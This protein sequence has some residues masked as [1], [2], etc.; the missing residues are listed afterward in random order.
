M[1][2]FTENQ[3]E[4]YDTFV[5]NRLAQMRNKEE[6]NQKSA[7]SAIRFYGAPILPPVLTDTRIAEMQQ[8]KE[9]AMRNAVSRRMNG[10]ERLAYVQTILHSVQMRHSPTL[11]DLLQE[12]KVTP[13]SLDS[14]DSSE[15]S[16]QSVNTV[17]E[18]NSPHI[19][20]LSSTT[21]SA[22]SS[23][24]VIPQPNHKGGWLVERCR[25]QQASESE[26]SSFNSASHCSVS[27][28]C[29]TRAIMEN[30]SGLSESLDRSNDGHGP[31]GTNNTTDVFLHKTSKR[32]AS[33]QD[34]ISYPP[35]DGE[36]LERSGQESSFCHDF[37]TRNE[38]SIRSDH[39]PGEESASSQMQSTK[40]QHNPPS[41]AVLNMKEGPKMKQVVVPV[42]SLD[43]CST[44]DIAELPQTPSI[45][46]SCTDQLTQSNP[47]NSETMDT[48]VPQ[49]Q[50]QPPN[51]PS[52]QDL[53]R[54]SQEYRWQQRM[55]RNQAKNARMQEKAQEQPRVEEK[56][57]SDKE[58]NEFHSKSTE[59][60]K[61]KEKR[62]VKTINT[63][64]KKYSEKNPVFLDELI[65]KKANRDPERAPEQ[66]TLPHSQP[67][68]QS[69]TQKV[70]HMT[71]EQATTDPVTS[72]EGH[73]THHS[74]P[75]PHF[76]PSPV[77]NKGSSSLP[78]EEDN[79]RGNVSISSSY[80]ESYE[81]DERNP[82]L[83]SDGPSVIVQSS[84]H[85][86]QLESGLSVLKELIS[87]LG[88][89]LM[90]I[91]G[92][93]EERPDEDDVGKRDQRN[94]EG[95]DRQSLESWRSVLE[96]T[97][98]QNNS[99]KDN[100]PSILQDEEKEVV[101]LE[102]FSLVNTFTL[103]GK[104]NEDA[105]NMSSRQLEGNRTQQPPAK[106][107]L[108]VAKW[109]PIPDV[110]R[111]VPSEHTAPHDVSVL[112]SSQS[113][114]TERK[115]ELA[116]DS[117]SFTSRLSV[118]RQSFDVD[119]PSEVWLLECSG[120][121][122]D[123]RDH[124][125]QVKGLTPLSVAGIEGTSSKVKRRLLM[126][127][128]DNLDMTAASSSEDLSE[129]KHSYGSSRV[130]SPGS[131]HFAEELKQVHAAQ[132]RALQEEHRRQ[133]EELCQALAMRYCLLQGSSFLWSL[134]GSRLG[135]TVTFSKI[136]QPPSSHLE[137]CRPLLLAAVKGYLTRR[138]LRTERV[139]QLVRTIGDTQQFLQAFQLPP[140]RGDICSKQDRL[141]Q[142]RVSLQLR[143]A[144]YE[145]YDIF[146][147]LSVTER[148]HLISLDRELARERVLRQQMG[149]TSC[150]KGRSSLSAAT[151]KSL[152]R[153]RGILIQKKV[154]ERRRGVVTTDDKTGF[155]SEQPLDTKRGRLRTKPAKS[156]QSF[157]SCRPR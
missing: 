38:D 139:A 136:S 131:D 113:H 39:F 14:S 67:L 49:A 17:A 51:R 37:I 102:E 89:S 78:D 116:E 110:F 94:N 86:N 13:K 58:N 147:C 18:M 155:M 133:Q 41:S 105:V 71:S 45:D 50:S 124:L 66:I 130:T 74:I 40:C 25:N 33:M 2:P 36:E 68:S 65:S 21:S 157:F 26:S 143:A 22:F 76:C 112:V 28:G 106:C 154:S 12:L 123:S 63:I 151:Q 20:P 129:V 141:L 4:D 5:Q 10:N 115:P 56:S 121:D 79:F 9:V 153:K 8:H 29:L 96:Y 100:I 27:L 93:C 149:H 119:T 43:G 32:I 148:M 95:P 98:E 62:F 54:K 52:L 16:H 11:E 61:T 97:D 144:R 132:V 90:E 111:N 72:L 46:C 138:L 150:P 19:G 60:R 59:G 48:Q 87:D 128:T 83:Q 82:G 104:I 23:S 73:G 135:D 53:L 55:L 15:S 88:S 1:L 70:N 77:Y 125:I 57:L 81:A 126:H 107:A 31:R 30:T 142:Q 122:Q 140:H 6:E 101:N 103:Q 118:D 156:S 91:E 69:Q 42:P 114:P 134:S 3:M 84:Q 137:H 34:I 92:K 117:H 44:S 109:M 80:K 99:K 146:F 120:S 64:C 152:L 108:S 85:I 35:I 75:V 24:R 145:M 47:A 127:A 7:S